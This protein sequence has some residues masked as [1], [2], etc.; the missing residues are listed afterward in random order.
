[1]ALLLTACG[2]GFICL[3]AGAL[4]RDFPPGLLQGAV[5]MPWPLK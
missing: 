4:N 3:M 1:L 2:I 5:D